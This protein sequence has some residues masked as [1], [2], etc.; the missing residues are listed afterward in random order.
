MNEPFIIDHNNPKKVEVFYSGEW[1]ERFPLAFI[2]KQCIFLIGGYE[3]Q[4]LDHYPLGC[5]C[6]QTADNWRPIQEPTY[7]A[8]TDSEFDEA[9]KLLWGKCVK[10]YNKKYMCQVSIAQPNYKKIFGES[11]E[12]LFTEYKYADTPFSTEWK[13]IGKEVSNA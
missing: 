3:T 6:Y 7:R 9:V 12:T 11:L 2:N 1:L 5:S 13:V 4:Y 8:F 10:H